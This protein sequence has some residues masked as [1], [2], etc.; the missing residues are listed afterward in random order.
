MD[1]S[2]MLDDAKFENLNSIICFNPDGNIIKTEGK[3][4]IEEI[5]KIGKYLSMMKSK[6]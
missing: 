5:I 6:G 1:V 2:E 4:P 3:I